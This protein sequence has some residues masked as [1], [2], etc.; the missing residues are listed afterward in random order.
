MHLPEIDKYASLNSPLHSWDPRLKLVSMG[1]LILAVVLLQDLELALLG[2]FIGLALV[3]LSRIPFTFVFGHMKWVIFFLIPFFIIMPLTIQ[4]DQVMQVSIIAISCHGLS[5][6]GLI[7]LRAIAAILLIFPMIG[8]MP[9][10]TTIK[11]LDRLKMPSKLIQ[12]TMFTYRYIFLFAE[13]ARKMSIALDSRGL[14]KKTNLHTMR[15]LSTMVGMLFVKS[16]ERAVKLHHAMISR[17]YRGNLKTLNGF[18]VNWVDV[19]KAIFIG[20][21]ASSLIFWGYIL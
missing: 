13:E 5:Y 14:V 15:T 10:A 20:T 19:I 21:L 7:A 3:Y 11:A 4:D 12:I 17:G 2:C 9:F 6:A 1:C 16:Y 18:R 8:T